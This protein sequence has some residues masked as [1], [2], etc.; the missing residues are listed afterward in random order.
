MPYRAPEQT[1]PRQ[2][3]AFEVRICFVVAVAGL[4]AGG[5]GWLVNWLA[6]VDTHLP[7]LVAVGGFYGLMG[8]ARWW[9]LSRLSDSDPPAPDATPRH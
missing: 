7:A 9:K 6:D 4:V 5:L 8:L 1:S 3:L 2:Q